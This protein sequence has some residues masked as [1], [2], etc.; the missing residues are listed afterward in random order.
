[1][2]EA[3]A[4]EAQRCAMERVEEI[5]CDMCDRYGEVVM[6]PP[7]QPL[8]IEGAPLSDARASAPQYKRFSEEVLAKARLN[9]E[10]FHQIPRGTSTL[11]QVSPCGAYRSGVRTC[12]HRHSQCSH[13]TIADAQP[14]RYTG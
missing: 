4:L 7:P 13:S 12:T 1:M 5:A 9:Y 14:I 3:E 10:D 8:P 6:P 11:E 2:R